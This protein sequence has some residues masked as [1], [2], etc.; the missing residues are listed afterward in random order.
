MK[1]SKIKPEQKFK[2]REQS[3]YDYNI[4]FI[5]SMFDVNLDE[6][7][8]DK[9]TF[10]YSLIDDGKCA[11]LKKDDKIVLCNTSFTG[12]DSNDFKGSD[13]ILTTRNFGL[14]KT[15]RDYKQSNDVVVFNL[16][17]LF[18]PDYNVSRYAYFNAEI[19]TSLLAT[20][21]TTRKT[22]LFK[23]ANEKQRR[24]L[25]EILKKADS[26]EPNILVGRPKLEEVDID[27]IESFDLYN[28]DDLNTI[29]ILTRLSREIQNKWYN[30]Y[31]MASNFAE[32]SAQQ[33]VQE[34]NH[35]SLSSWVIPE[36][37]FNNLKRS[38]ERCN[39]VFG[40]NF[41]IEY[42]KLWKLA[43]EQI[44]KGGSNDEFENID[45]VN[46]NGIDGVDDE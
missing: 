38:F 8:I 31:G 24:E 21:K 29:P 7:G 42:S 41:T 46:D 13:V 25:N 12:V 40:T 28:A 43:F 15:I 20:I 39:K 45:R 14:S 33:S 34:I 16:N 35:G 23:V 17:D 30:L 1:Y 26:G 44:S 2:V 32:K 6:Y 11:L 18:T 3:H 5:A 36:L 10:F 22:K 4:N 37:Y 9:G 27:P 19:D